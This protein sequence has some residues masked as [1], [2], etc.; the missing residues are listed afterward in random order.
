[1]NAIQQFEA[2]LPFLKELKDVKNDEL[3]FRPI[4]EGKWSSA[5]IVAHLYFWDQYIQN[6]RLPLM[7][8]LSDV[9]PGG[10]DIQQFNKEAESFAHSG[11][12]KVELIEKF[13]SNRKNLIEVLAIVDLQKEFAIK[14]HKLTIEKYFLDMAEHDEHHMKQI[15][16]VY[17]IR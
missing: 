5:A 4:S 3:F 16:S 9:P 14:D 11:I 8:K 1:M 12:G 2:I 10:I 7:L 13:I 15:T 17:N 6:E